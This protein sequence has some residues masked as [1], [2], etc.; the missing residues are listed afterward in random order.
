MRVMARNLSP[1]L[2]LVEK[3]VMVLFFEVTLLK[4]GLFWDAISSVW[5]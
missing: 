4:S 1:D 3:V 5:C 2:T